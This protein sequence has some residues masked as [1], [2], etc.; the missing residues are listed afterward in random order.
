MCLVHN[1]YE[2]A[3]DVFSPSRTQKLTLCKV[4]E[5]RQDWHV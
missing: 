2:R 5:E 4:D 3:S 1:N